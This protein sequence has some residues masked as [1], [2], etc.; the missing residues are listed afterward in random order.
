M[1]HK[2][3]EA[4]VKR[5]SAEKRSW[6]NSQNSLENFCCGVLLYSCA[7]AGLKT[8]N[9]YKEGLPYSWFHDKFSKNFKNGYFTKTPLDGCFNSFNLTIQSYYIITSY[10]FCKMCV[11]IC[12]RNF[13]LKKPCIC[14]GNIV[15]SFTTVAMI[16]KRHEQ[17]HYKK[18]FFNMDSVE[19]KVQLEP[20]A[21]DAI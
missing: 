1:F 4:A 3:L 12:W 21:V 11:H 19:F 9:F 2:P 5:A 15:K 17:R 8:C 18:L 13:M 14:K 16:L 6:K 7:V 20:F 10:I